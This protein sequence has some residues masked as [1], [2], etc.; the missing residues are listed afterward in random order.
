[1]KLTCEDCALKKIGC[2]GGEG[3]VP[4]EI[5]VVCD[6]PSLEDIN[7]GRAF[8]GKLNEQIESFLTLANIPTSIVY[9]TN[10]VK[11]YVKPKLNV[12]IVSIRKCFPYLEKEITT[13]APKVIMLMGATAYKGFKGRADVGTC[14]Y[15]EQ[16]K[17]WI[18]YSLHPMKPLYSGQESDYTTLM[19]HFK[20]AKELISTVASSGLARPPVTIIKTTEELINLIPALAQYPEYGLDCETMG[21]NIPKDKTLTLG[22]ANDKI[23]V[24]I[25]L[26]K[27][28]L[29]IINN[30]FT[31]IS[32]IGHNLKFDLQALRGYG[33]IAAKI[34][35]DTMLEHYVLDPLAPSHELVSL[36]LKELQTSFDKNLDYSTLFNN[37]ITQEIL[38]TLAERGALDAYL[39]YKLHQKYMPRIKADPAA[40]DFF[41]KTVMPICS[42]L[43]EIEFNGVMINQ[44]EL[45][46]TETTIN[47]QLKSKEAELLT[48]PII[49]E[50]EQKEGIEAINFGSPKQMSNLIYKYLKFPVDKEKGKTTKKE[51]IEKLNEQVKHPLIT[52]LLE[53]RNMAKLR[54]TYIDGIK[55]G[56]SR[57]DDG[58]LHVDFS[59]INVITGRLSCSKPNLQTIPKAVE[60]A[61][62]IRKMFG[63][64]PGYSLVEMD[65]KQLEV[66]IWAHLSKDAALLNMLQEDG[67]IHRKIASKVK[68][69]PEDQIT[70]EQRY[71]A[72]EIVFGLIYGMGVKALAERTG[73]TIEEATF[74]KN[75][76]FTTFPEA[77]IWIKQVQD[78]GLKYQY[79]LTPFN[80]RIPI[81]YNPND[82]EAISSAQ[83]HAVNYPIQST[84]GELTNVT[85]VYLLDLINKNNIDAKIILN[86]HDSLIW[87]IKDEEIEKFKPVALEAIK[88]TSDR[89][90]F[91]AFLRA[92]FK[93]GKNLGEQKDL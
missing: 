78:F 46:A 80:R 51:V 84:G 1:M 3:K 54:D 63:A 11:G 87:E 31:T 27:D 37:G 45:F 35:G 2:V 39:S 42:L 93:I 25:I 66:R 20:K 26:N 57:S 90:N 79:V 85:G 92:S 55:D 40:I 50:F 77:T 59:Q 65:F 56:L 19:N 33:L 53:Y 88:K 12:S 15:D 69:I 47:Y 64:R 70:D 21:L 23:T 72:K 52:K 10:I 83:R 73:I 16:Y 58:R 60:N 86:V 61:S 34:S 68:G 76:F 18:L 82:K 30:L 6:K 49:K 13:V 74:I 17:A 48:D 36:C 8:S 43:A 75:E 44:E 5:M 24:G 29:P 89:I 7:N 71:Q 91:R 4:T 38:E 32:I 81:I 14:Y 9:K 22:L 28:M 67:D 41:E 62:I